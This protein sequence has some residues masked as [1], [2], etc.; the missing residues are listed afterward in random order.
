MG[1]ASYCERF[2]LVVGTDSVLDEEAGGVAD[3]GRI[4]RNFRFDM[5]LVLLRPR[6]IMT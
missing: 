4:G 3:L 6:C 1:D 2:A 5:K